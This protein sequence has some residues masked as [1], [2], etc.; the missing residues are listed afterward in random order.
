MPPSEMKLPILSRMKSAS[1]S[2]CSMHMEA[3][4][5]WHGN[6]EVSVRLGWVEWGSVRLGG[7]VECDVVRRRWEEMK[8]GNSEVKLRGSD[9]SEVGWSLECGVRSV[10]CEMRSVGGGRREIHIKVV[11]FRV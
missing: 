1:L 5:R 8:G 10:E 7:E 6:M 9:W 2:I 4:V 3:A 11:V